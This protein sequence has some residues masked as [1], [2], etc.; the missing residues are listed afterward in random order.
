ML[1]PVRTR[2]AISMIL[3]LLSALCLLKYLAWA[4]LYSGVYGLPSQAKTIAVAR[5]WGLVYLWVLLLVE[6][7]LIANLMVT[8]KLEIL[9]CPEC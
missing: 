9:I 4:S 8:I 6:C 2:V 3:I 1:R 5:H 7:A